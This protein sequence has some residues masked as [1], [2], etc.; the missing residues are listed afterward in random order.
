[1][2]WNDPR[3]FDRLKA[4]IQE[5][6]KSEIPSPNNSGRR[7]TSRQ[8][9]DMNFSLWWQQ[10]GQNEEDAVKFKNY[11]LENAMI[12]YREATR[13]YNDK[14]LDEIRDDEYW[15][16]PL[17]TEENDGSQPSWLVDRDSNKSPTF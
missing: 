15:T 2:K 8:M 13:K 1:M 5:Q 7:Q 14:C 6:Y 16:Q 3:A 4:I 12:S 11:S 9:D 17:W 10:Y